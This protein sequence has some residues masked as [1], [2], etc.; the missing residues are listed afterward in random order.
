MAFVNKSTLF[1]FKSGV[2][3]FKLVHPPRIV[4]KILSNYN[5]LRLCPNFINNLEHCTKTITSKIKSIPEGQSVIRTKV[6]EVIGDIHYSFQDNILGAKNLPESWFTIK[7]D[8]SRKLKPFLWLETIIIDADKRGKGY[9]KEVLKQLYLESVKHGCGGR[10]MCH[11]AWNSHYFYGK[12]GWQIFGNFEKTISKR[13]N[14]I[15][16]YEA[17][18][19]KLRLDPTKTS[20][21]N[22]IMK[23][24]EGLKS[25]LERIKKGLPYAEGN[26]MFN[27]TPENIAMLCS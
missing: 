11:S 4:P 22:K 3:C 8:G 6:G 23:Y 16:E 13:T 14:L 20:E 10:M 19:A 21:L 27:P 1:I 15:L 18:I 9:G 26:I 2:Q 17:E 24:L 12:C 25:D 7:P 5:E